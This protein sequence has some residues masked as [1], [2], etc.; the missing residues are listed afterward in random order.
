MDCFVASPAL[1]NRFAFVAGNDGR[2]IVPRCLT[3]E[4]ERAPPHPDRRLL[5]FCVMLPCSACSRML[6]FSSSRWPLVVSRGT[7]GALPGPLWLWLSWGMGGGFWSSWSPLSTEQDNDRRGGSFPGNDGMQRRH[8][9]SPA[10]KAGLVRIRRLQWET[11]LKAIGVVILLALGAA[12]ER[13]GL[14]A[15]QG[16]GAKSGPAVAR[17]VLRCR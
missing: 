15:G 2:Q 16:Q 12:A 11:V 6:F 7:L 4:I 1:R 17:D 5:V 9:L 13:S 8:A 10:A 14:R 3:F